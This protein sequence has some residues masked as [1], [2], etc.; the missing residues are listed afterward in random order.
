MAKAKNPKSKAKAKRRPA[1]KSAPVPVKLS[2]DS[3]TVSK[4]L[5]SFSSIQ[6]QGAVKPA[7]DRVLVSLT[8]L[9]VAIQRNE[10]KQIRDAAKAVRTVKRTEAANARAVN[11]ME[12]NKAKQKK[13]AARIAK[14]RA[15]LK[16]LGG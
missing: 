15:E 6:F 13:N 8:K 7:R 14:I 10:A 11:K 2:K 9:D 5:L 12:R 1:K 4:F 3:R 16:R